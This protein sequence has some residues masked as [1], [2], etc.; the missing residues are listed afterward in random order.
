M[1]KGITLGRGG[2]SKVYLVCHNNKEYACKVMSKSPR[3]LKEIAISLELQKVP[4]VIKVHDVYD[5]ENNYYIV[6]ERCKKISTDYMQRN[7]KPFLHNTLSILSYIHDNDI[8]HNDI[9][10]DNIMMGNDN[11]LRIIDF[12]CS[13]YANDPI[14]SLSQT[15]PVYCSVE[16]L[17]SETC[18]KSDIWSIGVMSF[19]LLTNK[20]PFDGNSV[21]EI[22]KEILMHTP[23]FDLITDLDGKNFVMACIDACLRCEQPKASLT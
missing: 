6:M 21:N 16:S 8:I 20:L 12:G 14:P 19:Y 22:F 2:Y 23:N 17:R 13:L 18:K 10:L 7:I 5:C 11:K 1:L 9:K 4:G 15:T 3:A